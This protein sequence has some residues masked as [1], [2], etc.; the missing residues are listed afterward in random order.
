MGLS[1]EMLREIPV[2]LM[3]RGIRSFSGVLSS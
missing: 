3:L 2:L 1:G